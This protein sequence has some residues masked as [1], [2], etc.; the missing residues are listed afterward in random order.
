MSKS[1]KGDKL[2]FEEALERVE[3]TVTR[4]EDKDLP[5]EDLIQHYEEGLKL[6][7]HCNQ[8]LAVAE[9]KITLLT[10]ASDGKIKTA[11]LA[12]QPPDTTESDTV[13]KSDSSPS[14]F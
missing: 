13:E 8:K 10:K 4:M 14:L 12:P 2:T 3:Q 5:L 9:E 11:T 1:P 7:E 6:I